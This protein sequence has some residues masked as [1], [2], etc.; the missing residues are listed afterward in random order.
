MQKAFERL[1][2]NDVFSD[3][4]D[5]KN[6]KKLNG[7]SQDGKMATAAELERNAWCTIAGIAGGFIGIKEK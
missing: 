2:R 4:Y 1:R 5:V 6:D 3:K 7:I